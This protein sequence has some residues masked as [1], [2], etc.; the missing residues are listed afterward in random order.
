[1]AQLCDALGTDAGTVLAGVGADHRVGPDFL[2]PG[3]GYGGSCLPKD[4]AGFIALGDSLGTN[5]LLAAASEAG[6]TWAREAVV[7][8]LEM[9][10]GSLSGQ[11]IGVLGLAF[12]AGTDDTRDSPGVH[13]VE[14]LER[15]GAEVRVYDPLV[16]AHDR[17]GIRVPTVGEAVLAA[18]AVVITTAS[19]EF[20]AL[21]PRALAAVMDG[22]II[23]DAVGVTDLEAWSD[24]GLAV[25]GIGRGTPLG[26][27]PVVWAPLQWTHATPVSS[28]M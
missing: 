25:Y 13:I 18:D 19:A 14:Q 1:V 11:R 28:G 4:V 16:S 5:T 22:N 20:A 17:T 27:H 10:L 23:F 24:V 9:L 15:R 12:K 2:R 6:N 7:D 26:F 3:P 8:K 21:E